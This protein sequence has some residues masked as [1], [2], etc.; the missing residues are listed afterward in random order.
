M[1]EKTLVIEVASCN[2]KKLDL[3]AYGVTKQRSYV[4]VKVGDKEEK[5]T[6]GLGLDP[7]W[8]ET[9]EFTV[10]DE[11]TTKC[12]VKF[13]MGAEGEEKQIGD[14]C[15][16]LLPALIINKPTYKGLIVP[17]GKV[18]MMFTAKGF[19]KEDVE[20]DDSALMDLLDGGEMMMDDDDEEEQ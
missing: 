8:E 17:G 5:T 7:T 12:F 15:E 6:V 14:E 1:A 2:V 18:D 11:A 4:V 20:V 3:K 13:M 19:G 10:T 16:Y 9:F